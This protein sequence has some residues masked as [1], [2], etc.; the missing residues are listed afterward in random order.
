M[1]LPG[2]KQVEDSRTIFVGRR[3]EREALVGALDR[4]RAGHPSSWLLVGEAGIGKT[5]IATELARD[6]EASGARVYWGRCRESEGAPAFWPW[7]EIAR[8]YLRDCDD[9]T[10]L[11]VLGANASDI[12]QIVPELLER[13][14]EIEPSPPLDGPADRFRLFQSWASLL[15]NASADTPL[16]LILD[17]LHWADGS[18]VALLEHVV[19]AVAGSAVV[20]VGTYRPIDVEHR[21]ELANT[22]GN[23]SRNC[24]SLF[25]SGLNHEEVEA[26]LELALG[27]ERGREMSAAVHER[28]EGN[29]LFVSEV[30][31]MLVRT[32]NVDLSLMPAAASLTDGIRHAIGRRLEVISAD[33]MRLLRSA[34]A[35][36]R[37]FDLQLLQRIVLESGADAAV[38]ATGLSDRLEEACSFDIV[39]QEEPWARYRFSH[40]LIQNTLYEGIAPSERARLHRAIGLALEEMARQGQQ[41]NITELAHH[42]TCAATLGAPDKA[43]QYAMQAG[44]HFRRR[45]AYE[46]AATQYSAALRLL[47]LPDAG[48]GLKASRVRMRG[49]LLLALGASQAC[50]ASE[51]GGGTAYLQ[52]VELGRTIGDPEL[53]AKGVLGIADPGNL[54]PSGD[55]DRERL[56]E[57]A[58]DG[59]GEGDHPLRAVLLTRSLVPAYYMQDREMALRRSAEALQIAERVCDEATLGQVLGERLLLLYGPDHLDERAALAKRVLDLAQTS[60]RRSLHL[61]G[62]N[63]SAINLLQR[64][65]VEKAREHLDRCTVLTE[66]RRQPFELWQAAVCRATLALLVGDFTQAESLATEACTIGQ[67]ARLPNAEVMLSIQ[68]FRLRLEQGRLEEI[69]PIILEFART[70]AHIPAARG[71]LALAYAHMGRLDEARRAFDAVASAR[72]ANYPRDSNWLTGL[73]DAAHVCWFLDDQER[74][75]PLYELLQPHAELAV[76]GSWFAACSGTVSHYLGLLAAVLERWDDAERQFA[77]A[78][79]KYGTMGAN[80]LLA[81]V[82]IDR[83]ETLLRSGDQSDKAETLVRA[84]AASCKQLGMPTWGAHA[85]MLLERQRPTKDAPTAAPR[86]PASEAGSLFRPDG[87]FWTLTYQ[88]QTARVR[89]LKGLHYLR[90]LLREPD[91]EFH[92]ADITH[93]SESNRPSRA[94]NE[95]SDIKARDDYRRRVLNLRDDLGQAEENNDALRATRIR[96]EI[97]RLSQHLAAA[98]SPRGLHAQGRDVALENIRKAVAKSIRTALSRI[99]SVHEPLWRHL[100]TA[101]RTGQFCSYR[102]ETKVDWLV[103]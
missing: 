16:L 38:D 89:D 45:F 62:H 39:R 25:L 10:A 55:I 26:Y 94:S 33:T 40:P 59:L 73:T 97:D 22:L 31:G 36:G 63:W 100:F 6:A 76:I 15:V 77:A 37:D 24:D 80:A 47:D 46:E 60:G 70:M 101:V 44:D 28:T 65:E 92:V 87:D 11:Q 41:V 88:G 68:I 30:A 93:G 81:R 91:R 49:E 54:S 21:S 67:A 19:S 27:A 51:I 98:Y 12:A 74:A 85:A 72:F 50:V 57:E 2:A 61:V 32:P 35:I 95:H 53:V 23:V 7:I 64:G 34:A 66:E 18:S 84:A 99:Q 48:D 75:K 79:S 103:D 71:P 56:I 8:A 96:E 14:P 43:V 29:A 102:P 86:E 69:E 58:L 1:P 5:R 83:A 3:A 20:I 17:D 13:F 9:R 4:A 52:A 78:E 90:L 82:R 42:F